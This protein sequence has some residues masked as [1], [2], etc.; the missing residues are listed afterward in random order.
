MHGRDAEGHLV[1]PYDRCACEVFRAW[2]QLGNNG[3]RK[4]GKTG[5]Q[6]R[7]ESRTNQ[8]DRRPG[9]VCKTSIPG[10]NPGGASKIP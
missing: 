1:V 10:S 2:E 9:L 8:Q 5:E 3:A 7:S 4:P 6:G